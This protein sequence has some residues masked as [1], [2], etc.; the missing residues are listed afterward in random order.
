MESG[1]ESMVDLRP[2]IVARLAMSVGHFCGLVDLVSLAASKLEM[3][4]S[5]DR[6]S[7]L[8]HIVWDGFKQG[9][10]K[11]RSIDEIRERYRYIV[12]M[13]GERAELDETASADSNHLLSA[14]SP[15]LR[16]VTGLLCRGKAAR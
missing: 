9:F 7:A 10:A 3:L 14:C 12:S 5:T 15:A 6:F 1:I 11:D 16:G 8:I 13:R 4:L 2:Q